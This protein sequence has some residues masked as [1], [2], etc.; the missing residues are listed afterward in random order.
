[1][2]VFTASAPMSSTTA[3][4]CAATIAGGSCNI[5]RTALVFCAAIAAITAQ[6][7][8]AVRKI[9]QLPPAIVAA[10][11]DAVVEDIGADAVKTG[12][13]LDAAIV[14]IVAARIHARRL[15]NLVVDPVMVAK[16]GDL[17]LRKDAMAALKKKLIPLATVV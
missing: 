6:N 12:M 10:Q 11:I 5:F 3:S 9:L 8:K 14:K 7:T 15:R 4:I 1:M 2:P 13:L 17:L 16:S